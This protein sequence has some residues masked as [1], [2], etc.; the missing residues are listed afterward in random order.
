MKKTSKKFPKP[1]EQIKKSF[2][3]LPDPFEGISVE[4]RRKILREVAAKS[5][6]DF[7]ESFPK[8]RD[9]FQNYDA[10]HLL[11]CCAYYLLTTQP[12][13][14]K[15]AIEG[16]IEFGYHHLELLQ[17][18]SLMLP[19]CG[20]PKPFI[21][22]I[23]NIQKS[24]KELTDLLVH[25]QYDFPEHLTDEE[26]WKRTVIF[27]MRFQTL[28]I[29]GWANPDQALKHL[30]QLFS[31][32]LSKIISE[33]YD[34]L[35]VVK[36]IETIAKLKGIV[37]DRLSE[38]LRKLARMWGGKSFDEVCSAYH[39]AFPGMEDDRE[40]MR[41]AFDERFEGKLDSLKKFFLVHS[42]FWLPEIYTFSFEKILETYATFEHKDGVRKTIDIWSYEFG[43]L[44]N[45]DPKH[46]LFTN[47]IHLKPFVKVEG[48]SFFWPNCG[49][50][51][52]ALPMMLEKIIPVKFRELYFSQRSKYL[53]DQ[54]EDL[55]KKS[56]PYGKVY[57]GS[58]W[59]NTPE[60][61]VEYENDLLVVIDSTVLI[62][63]C[64]S[65]LVDP[66][67]RRGGEERLVTTLKE[68][69]VDGSAQ[70]N[71]FL[72]F[73]QNNLKVH[74]FKTKHG[75][76]NKVDVSMALRFIP[77]TVTYENLGFVGSNLKKCIRAGLITPGTK[78][79]PSY[80][81]TDLEVVLETLDSQSERIHYLS[82]RAEIEEHAE[83]MG[84][85]SDL[86]ACYLKTSFSINGWEE[87]EIVLNIG[88]L[89]SELN[90]YFMAKA[91]NVQ[92][93]KPALDLS[94]W[95]RNVLKQVESR[96]IPWW[97]E[98]SYVLLSLPRKNQ[99]N[100]KKELNKLREK[101]NTGNACYKDN[102][103]VFGTN[104]QNNRFV[105]IGYPYKT[106]DRKERN[107]AMNE[108]CHDIDKDS[109]IQG[110]VVLGVNSKTPH[111]PY[112]VLAYVPN[113][114]IREQERFKAYKKD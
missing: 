12:G 7:E 50:F 105:I 77:F 6:K 98:I 54:V 15:E 42:E 31:D 99:D 104:S 100:F 93:T 106:D 16:K 101:I 13:V 83:Y 25:S 18:I 63:E 46:F 72:E 41:E 49:T 36:L 5:K 4:N 80:C 97:A 8:L 26:L 48:D 55:C 70:A 45:E 14:D 1:Y 21:N 65:G 88:N 29:R 9:W 64:K 111:Y 102:W 33:E 32:P 59:K 110:I 56:F 109:S 27:E 53:E 114:K 76:V 107:N 85:E 84:D 2:F 113:I 87:R 79:R 92:V 74:E 11:S 91:D 96:R 86:F 62:I 89:S 43:D 75:I 22:E 68:L 30:K 24:L 52:H 51:T 66:P 38:H 78:I 10:I 112:D 108:I 71:R 73:L 95:W 94:D 44:K 20:N 17:A 57:R 47:P 40:K 19:R 39:T 28:T 61:Q 58:L 90:Y 81:I 60:S 37:E 67:A 35:D 23:S 82:R 3:N 34:G 69:V 103:I